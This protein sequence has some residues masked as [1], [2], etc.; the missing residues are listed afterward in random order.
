MS[1]PEPLK[2]WTIRIRAKTPKQKF[3]VWM[4]D[5]YLGTSSELF[6]NYYNIHEVID[7]IQEIVEVIKNQ[8]EKYEE[9]SQ[10]VSKRS[11]R[12]HRFKGIV[13]GLKFT[14]DLIKKAFVKEK[15]STERLRFLILKKQV[16]NKLK[17]LLKEIEKE[18]D[19]IEINKSNAPWD[20]RIANLFSKEVDGFIKGLKFAKNLI[21]KAFSGVLE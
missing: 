11:L 14:E 15:E 6:L 20:Y 12:F 21:K 3:D 10:K 5:T 1:K 4:D 16:E 13:D 9:L 2:I 8:V 7:K 18:I 19:R 17:W